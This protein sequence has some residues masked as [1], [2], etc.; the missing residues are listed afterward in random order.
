MIVG[1]GVDIVEIDRWEAAARRRGGL[2]A[3]LFTAAERAA[4]PGARGRSQYFAG[5][6]AAKE[7]VLK[8]LGTGLRGGRW[9]DVEIV[10][11]ALGRPVARLH[12]AM[13]QRARRLG[14]AEV[15]VSISHARRY[16]VATAMAL[17]GQAPAGEGARPAGLA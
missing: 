7:A 8:A 4:A 16:A 13:A 17:G 5:R 15:V 6:F 11:D 10:R 9:Q 2:L 12:G 3:R 1:L 14:V